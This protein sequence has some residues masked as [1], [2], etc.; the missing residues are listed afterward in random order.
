MRGAMN[1]RFA[2]AA[3]ASFFVGFV[4]LTSA[5]GSSSG[6]GIPTETLSPSAPAPQPEGNAPSSSGA[7]APA[8]RSA[9]EVESTKL[10]K[11]LDGAHQEETDAVLAVKTPTCGLRVLTSGPQ[12]L[13]AKKLH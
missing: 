12:K 9:C 10:Q 11:G 7:P 6:D 13:D 5:C 4:A 2:R 8:D 1:S 3:R